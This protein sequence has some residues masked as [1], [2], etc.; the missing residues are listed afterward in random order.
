MTNIIG[1]GRTQ[2]QLQTDAQVRSPAHE[3]QTVEGQQADKLAISDEASKRLEGLPAVD[4][5]QVNTLADAMKM[6]RNT[7]QMILERPDQARV[8]HVPDLG[9]RVAGLVA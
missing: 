1:L 8:A 4:A 5:P 3:K 9:S 7:V 6:A 2:L